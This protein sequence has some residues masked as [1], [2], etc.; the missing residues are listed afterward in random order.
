[1]EVL[2]TKPA[3]VD[4][5]QKVLSITFQPEVTTFHAVIQDGEERKRVAFQVN[6]LWSQMSATQKTIIKAWY[7][8]LAV[9]ALN[10]LNT[11]YNVTVTEA[12]V[13]GDA[14]LD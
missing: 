10:E 4:A 7:K 3:V 2:I 9:L 1:M 5:K 8:R 13:K 14:I 6:G 11:E 12:D